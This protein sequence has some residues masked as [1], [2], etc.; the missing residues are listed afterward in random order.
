MSKRFIKSVSLILEKKSKPTLRILLEE[1]EETKSDDF[2][3]GPDEDEVTDE[4]G[5]K[6]EIV[7]L[8]IAL[9]P[10]LAITTVLLLPVLVVPPIVPPVIATALEF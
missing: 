5:D 7:L 6:E 4:E 1:D 2:D 9:L 10:M 8:P 3:M